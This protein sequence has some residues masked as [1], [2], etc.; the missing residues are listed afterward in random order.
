MRGTRPVTSQFPSAVIYNLR[1]LLQMVRDED[2][3]KVVALAPLFATTQREDNDMATDEELDAL[4]EEAEVPTGGGG[5]LP[6]GSYTGTVISAEVRDS[7]TPWIDEELSLKLQVTEGDHAGKTTFCDIELKPLTD[8]NDQPS[9]GKVKFVKWQLEAL[10]YDGKLSEVKFGV[11]GLY[12][13]VVEFEQKVTD[14]LD[15]EGNP[16]GMN[17]RQPRINENTGKPY[18][19]R[20]VTL[21]DNVL[22]GSG[23][24]STETPAP[25]G[26]SQVY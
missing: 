15:A 2:R 9:K 22:P 16:V 11:A 18:V 14:Y 6:A 12:G 5:L 17:G 19:D 20:E 21:K 26:Q 25:T 3:G 8:K 13:A 1:L 10:G 4:Y 23:A 24:R 7:K